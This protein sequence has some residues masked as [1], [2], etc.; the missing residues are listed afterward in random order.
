MNSRIICAF[1]GSGKSYYVKNI[2]DQESVIDLDSNE[3]T[4]GH[5]PDGKVRNHDFP[6]NYIEDIKKHIGLY[7]TILVSCHIPIVKALVE[8]GLEP[9][10]IYPEQKSLVEYQMRYKNRHDAQP[11]IDLLSK[12]WDMF[13]SELQKQNGCKHIVLKE[14]QYISNVL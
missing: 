12:N 4:S 2:A 9:I 8:Q 13:L 1:P 14:G 6:A 3:Y 11:F 7:Q 5:T 10:L